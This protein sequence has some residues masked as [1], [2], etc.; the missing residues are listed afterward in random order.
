MINLYACA[1]G[2]YSLLE[3]E[4]GAE[5]ESVAWDEAICVRGVALEGAKARLVTLGLAPIQGR[6]QTCQ[7][8]RLPAT[9]AIMLH[10][11]ALEELSST[12]LVFVT[13]RGVQILLLPSPCIMI[14]CSIA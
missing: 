6:C 7:G 9:T 5:W 1:G 2:S 14:S 13:Q 12:K 3:D 10:P 4:V 11:V 8:A